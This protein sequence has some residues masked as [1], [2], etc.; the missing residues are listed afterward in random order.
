MVV[1]G[2][3]GGGGSGGV[4]DGNEYCCMLFNIVLLDIGFW[5]CAFA[6]TMA[7]YR[8]CIFESTIYNIVL[9]LF[10]RFYESVCD[11][12]LYLRNVLVCMCLRL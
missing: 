7:I 5:M 11:L 9:V 3:G 10:F 8:Y 4:D 12:R 1:V 6:I 2:G